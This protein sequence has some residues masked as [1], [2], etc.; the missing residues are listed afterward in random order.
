MQIAKI[1]FFIILSLGITACTSWKEDAYTGHGAQVQSIPTLSMPQDVNSAPR[2]QYY[3]I[4]D[5]VHER[6][7]NTIE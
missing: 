1:I 6:Q 7:N 3:P 5:V 2:R 4:P